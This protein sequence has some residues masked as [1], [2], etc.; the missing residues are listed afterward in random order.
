MASMALLEGRSHTDSCLHYFG[1]G[2][3]ER[4][5]NI[6]LQHSPPGFSIPKALIGVLTEKQS[7]LLLLLKMD[8]IKNMV[9]LPSV[10]LK[11]LRASARF[12]RRYSEDELSSKLSQS[13]TVY[14]P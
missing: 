13:V 4:L 3:L 1:Q 11:E 2:A 7:M 14:S 10:G 12:R 8:K 6:L 5:L 9:F